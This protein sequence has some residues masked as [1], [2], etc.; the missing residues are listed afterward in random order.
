MEGGGIG[1]GIGLG[2]VVGEARIVVVV[3]VV[4]IAAD[5]LTA[6]IHRILR[7]G[8]WVLFG[9]SLFGSPQGFDGACLP[10]LMARC[11]IAIV[12]S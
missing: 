8:I 7:M 12:A 4:V 10:C 2:I 5:M 11:I 3:V 9:C 6:P 1:L